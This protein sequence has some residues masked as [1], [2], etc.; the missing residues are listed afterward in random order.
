MTRISSLQNTRIRAIRALRSRKERERTGLFFVEGALAVMEAIQLRAEIKTLVIAPEL[1]VAHD[2][3]E[4]VQFQQQRGVDCVEVT[5][6]VFESLASKDVAH[7]LSAVVRQRW[8][9]LSHIR[10]TPNDCWVG[11]DA[12]QYPGN[13]GT[14]LRTC[15]AVGAGGLMLFGATTD[16]YDPASVRASV[17]A[18]LSQQIVR[19]NV[20]SFA[21]WRHRHHVRVVGTS[22][23]ATLDYRAA[24]YTAPAVLLMGSERYGLSPE[25]QT[26]CDAMVYIPM[27]GRSDSLNLAVATSLMLYEVF[28]CRW[29]CGVG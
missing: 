21:A 25:L 16:P 18:V 29:P 13:L 15:D 8:A 12:V 11:L 23:N 9:C 27:V 1:V 28:R 5:P 10:P 17:G 4:L 22:P 6:E 2:A 3:A 19:T 14:V 24:D 7:G 20:E 26:L